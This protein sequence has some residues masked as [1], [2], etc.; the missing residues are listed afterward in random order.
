M[1]TVAIRTERCK[2]CG[3]CVD[4][5]PRGVLSLD[6]GNLTDKGYTPAKAGDMSLCTGC[7][8]CYRMCPD[9]AVTVTR[10]ETA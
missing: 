4:A 8:A 1:F 10:A 9:C 5:C 7:G 3:L 2:G 6:E